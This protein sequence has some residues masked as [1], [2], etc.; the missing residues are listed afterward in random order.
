[1]YLPIIIRHSILQTYK[2]ELKTQILIFK[3]N[4]VHQMFLKQKKNRKPR[5]KPSSRTVH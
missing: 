4:Y 5:Q 3:A 2:N 1:M